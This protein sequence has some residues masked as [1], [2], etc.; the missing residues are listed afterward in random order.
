LSPAINT[1][2]P[3]AA[4]GQPPHEAENGLWPS[5]HPAK[6]V[7]MGSPHARG[8][9]KGT[10]AVFAPAP[11]APVDVVLGVSSWD[12]GDDDA[13]DIAPHRT[14]APPAAD[15]AAVPGADGRAAVPAA[16][17]TAAVPSVTPT[18]SIGEGPGRVPALPSA[19]GVALPTPTAPTPAA[20]PPE[21][22]S[23]PNAA[24]APAPPPP[25]G[26]GRSLSWA[27][28]A[29][30]GVTPPPPPTPCRSTPTATSGVATARPAASSPPPRYPPSGPPVA[31]A[32]VKLDPIAAAAATRQA[33]RPSAGPSI[34]TP[35]L[36]I[37]AP[38]APGGGGGEQA[39]AEPLGGARMRAAGGEGVEEVASPP[40]RKEPNGCWSEA[41]TASCEAKNTAGGLG[42]DTEGGPA[43]GTGGG[44]GADTA[45]GPAAPA[46]PSGVSP[47]SRDG[48]AVPASA[49]RVR[50]GSPVPLGSGRRPR[51]ILKLTPEGKRRSV[52]RGPGASS[53]GVVRGGR[54]P[55]ARCGEGSAIAAG[56]AAAGDGG[57]RSGALGAEAMQEGGTT[58]GA[59]PAGDMAPSGPSG[60]AAA[61]AHTIS[62]G[63]LAPPSAAV[64]HE[65]ADGR[66]GE[67]PAQVARGRAAR[68]GAVGEAG[69]TAAEVWGGDQHAAAH[70][71]QVAEHLSSWPH[72]PSPDQLNSQPDPSAQLPPNAPAAPPA[73]PPPAP[74]KTSWASVAAK[75]RPPRSITPPKQPTTPGRDPT[76]PSRQPATPGGA[77]TWQAGS[78]SQ[79]LVDS[80]SAAQPPPQGMR[81]SLQPASPPAPAPDIAAWWDAMMTA[82]TS[83]GTGG[84]E[85]PPCPAPRPLVNSGNT[86]FANAVIQALLACGAFR[87]L[88]VELRR[89]RRAGGPPL[90]RGGVAVSFARFYD[91]VADDGEEGSPSPQRSSYHAGDDTHSGSPSPTRGSSTP[92]WGRPGGAP[93]AVRGAANGHRRTGSDATGIR[94]GGGRRRGGAASSR[95]AAAIHPVAFF[96]ESL[97]DFRRG[98]RR[99]AGVPAAGERRNA[100]HPALVSTALLPCR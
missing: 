85:P 55:S 92:P 56:A 19:V 54:S 32:A 52:G 67:A 15:R 12:E 14:A 66:A 84:A 35:G 74:G 73:A 10:R 26:P 38:A 95:G 28:V 24:A 62:A 46:G 79:A 45:G 93:P 65:G 51:R 50:A 80:P 57:L 23:A 49:A 43:T 20:P 94:S 9:V 22:I 53:E 86:C 100:H 63:Y 31:S 21:A 17:A 3:D 70:A 41:G 44:P 60:G 48:V 25:P 83:V 64:T 39:A 16:A 33:F 88:L 47:A 4:V 11:Y 42:A 89:R 37:G 2:R 99:R 69:V 76:T 97:R 98:T 78:P 7:G 36:S 13:V 82:A 8:S 72:G 27:A 71:A 90:P 5:L 6:A 77:A 1:V 96:D 18:A 81:G 40:P 58:D 61:S 87:A 75:I 59:M 29:A 30:S 34:G 68:A 91:A